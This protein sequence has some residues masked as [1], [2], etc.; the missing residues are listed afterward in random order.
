MRTLDDLGA[1][2]ERRWAQL[3]TAEPTTV[4]HVVDLPQSVAGIPLL[5][6][7]APDG[8]RLL[9]PFRANE[10]RGFRELR[11]RGID[12]RAR[13]LEG[14]DGNRWFLDVVC[15]RRD[16]RWLF[17][18]FVA[19]VL[20]RLQRHPDASPASIVTSSYSAWRALF[21]AA[22]RRLTV[23][24][25]TGLF[26]ELD[27]LRRLV[28][29]SS[30]AT[31]RWR[32]PMQDAHD[33][34][35]PPNDLEVKTTLS[36]EDAV[37][38]VHGLEQL[39][40]PAGGSL[41]LVHLRVETPADDGTSVPSLIEQ[42]RGTESTGHLMSLLAASGY[43]DEHAESY[44]PFTFRVIEENWYLV[45]DA[46]PRLS[47]ATFPQGRVPEGLS[48]FRYLLDLRAVTSPVLRVGEAETILDAVAR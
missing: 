24:Q 31:R 18:S 10:H 28:A 26:G 21:A 38:H 30:T 46:F 7:L 16:L 22:E 32:G 35:A 8:A 19:D 5:L 41:H 44:E 29:R 14:S 45:D 48:D 20:L 25:L 37:V 12:I 13:Q 6:G 34:V 15:V 17:S 23:K 42:I 3:D 39:V 4:L 27:V 33:F 47:P 9:V 11:S 36:T 40:P 43:H 1:E 2:I